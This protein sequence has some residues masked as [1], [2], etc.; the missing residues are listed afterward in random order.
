MLVGGPELSVRKAKHNACGKLSRTTQS[1]R[2]RPPGLEGALPALLGYPP[3]HT[4]A[5]RHQ[6]NESY[7]LSIKLLYSH[8]VKQNT[9]TT[10]NQFWLQFAL[11]WFKIHQRYLTA[12]QLAIWEKCTKNN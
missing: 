6:Q 7:F 10:K 9:K 4:T 8:P 3:K 11:S 12:P 5:Y 2:D 1:W